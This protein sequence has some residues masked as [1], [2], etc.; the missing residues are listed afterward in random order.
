MT[1]FSGALI[2]RQ[3]LTLIDHDTAPGRQQIGEVVH[4]PIQPRV[5]GDS[6]ML[7]SN[8]GIRDASPAMLMTTA[9]HVARHPV[10]L[11]GG[12]GEP[13]QCQRLILS[14][15]TA[16]E[17]DL[18]EQRL[19]FNNALAGGEQNRLRRTRRTFF[20]HGAELRNVEHFLAPQLKTHT[21]TQRR[22]RL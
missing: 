4:R 14:N 15:A 6:I 5:S 18:P 21:S 10:P 3:C 7:R 20:E 2:Q 13:A 1:R 19:R 22:S 9:Q 16:I 8:R 17:Q 12:D 11:P